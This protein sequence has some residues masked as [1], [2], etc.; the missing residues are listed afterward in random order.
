MAMTATAAATSRL[1]DPDPARHLGLVMTVA[2][3]F[4][5]VYPTITFDDFASAGMLG[6]CHAARR[7]DPGRGVRFTTFATP[8]VECCMFRELWSEPLIYLPSYYYARS[9]KPTRMR[10]RLR[11][12]SLPHRDAGPTPE[13]PDPDPALEAERRDRAAA[14]ARAIDA[15]PGRQ[16]QVARLRLAGLSCTQAAR[17]LGICRQGAAQAWLR[18]Q[19]S[20]RVALAPLV[21]GDH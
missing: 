14:V 21:Q 4:H 7:Y 6:L 19:K 8:W 11:V 13:A 3:R 9:L 16:R 20:L 5:R 12:G 15:L 2:D 17:Q 1:Y 18:A 10:L